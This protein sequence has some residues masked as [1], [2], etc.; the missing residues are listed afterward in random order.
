[1]TTSLS[2]RRLDHVCEKPR[3]AFKPL[4]DWAGIHGLI[5]KIL[6][7][8]FGTCLADRTASRAFRCSGDHA[9]REGG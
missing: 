3:K 4:A 8:A 2:V 9:L 1:M 5:G 7:A 6:R